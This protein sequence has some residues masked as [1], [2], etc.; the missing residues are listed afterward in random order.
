MGWAFQLIPP[1]TPP[2]PL[3]FS[4]GE[5]RRKLSHCGGCVATFVRWNIA[6]G[7][8]IKKI[9]FVNLFFFFVGKGQLTSSIRGCY[10][11]EWPDIG[12]TLETV[13]LRG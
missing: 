2:P 9:L 12:L 10:Y 4:S 8:E 13:V 5:R 3:S 1:N 7:C 6:E 11:L